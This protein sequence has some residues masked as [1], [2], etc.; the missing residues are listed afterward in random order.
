MFNLYPWEASS[1]LK[2]N[3]GGVDLVEKDV[4]RVEGGETVFG[5]GCIV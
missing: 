1:F 3:K 2:G 4:S 5:I